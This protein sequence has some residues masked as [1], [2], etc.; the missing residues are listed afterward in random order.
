MAQRNPLP[1]AAA[2][3]IRNLWPSFV[4]ESVSGGGLPQYGRIVT[5]MSPFWRRRRRLLRY[6]LGATSITASRR[7]QAGHLLFSG[8]TRL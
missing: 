8:N 4:I 2:A 6:T 3:D 1:S 5:C 7:Y